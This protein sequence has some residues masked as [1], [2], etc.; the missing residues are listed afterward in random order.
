VRL[1]ALALRDVRNIERAELEFPSAG[2]AIVGNNGQG[3]TNLLEAIAYLGTLRSIRNARDRDLIRHGAAVAHLRGEAHDVAPHTLTIGLER[4][5][6][7]KRIVLDGVDVRR[8]VDALGVLPSVSWAPSDVTLVSGGPGERRRYMD[9][10]L[11]L[12]TPGYLRALRRYR[13]ALERRNA[14]LRD[15]AT[16]RGPGDA[17]VA[18][19]EPLLAESGAEL[20]RARRAWVTSHSAEFTRMAGALGEGAAA[21]LR[22]E[23]DAG[24]EEPVVERLTELLA[25]GR[26]RDVQLRATCTGPHRDELAIALD[27]RDARAFASAGQQ[28]TAAIALR[29]LEART[30][31]EGGRGNPVLLLDDPFA[32]LDELRVARTLAILAAEDTGQI[33][34]AVP[35]D[36]D[37]PADFSGLERWR[38]NAGAFSR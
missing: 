28:R 8:Q 18:A 33:V 21:T 38:V 16:R 6:G 1:T 27:S 37:I 35:R 5:T 14:T 7:R 23:T 26:A 22:Y 10:M 24:E 36:D 17:A 13:G 30:L 31:R 29:L 32:E 19:W 34:L 3:K 4:A 2:V 12:T 15:A 11:A 25:R 9:V 20:V